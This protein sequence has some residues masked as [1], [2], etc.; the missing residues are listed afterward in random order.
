MKKIE[1]LEELPEGV[2]SQIELD[3][4]LAE[5]ENLEDLEEILDYIRESVGYEKE[6]KKKNDY[7]YLQ[8][9][10]K[11]N[12]HKIMAQSKRFI[13]D[14]DCICDEEFEGIYLL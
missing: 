1:S 5:D 12:G 13:K 14:Y 6:P 2:L 9:T 10:K 7:Y 11:I 8:F 4:E 3:M